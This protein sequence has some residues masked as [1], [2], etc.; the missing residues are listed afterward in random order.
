MS[1]VQNRG[2]ICDFELA[3]ATLCG[4]LR[5]E[6]QTLKENCDFA[7]LICSNWFF[8]PE[9]LTAADWDTTGALQLARKP[10]LANLEQSNA[11]IAE[12][13]QAP[14][15]LIF[16]LNNDGPTKDS[17]N[18]SNRRNMRD[19]QEVAEICLPHGQELQQVQDKSVLN[20]IAGLKDWPLGA[21]K[22]CMAV[23]GNCRK[24]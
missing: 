6:C 19:V 15:V 1:S 24:Q 9:N 11:S 18:E 21:F 13:L 8:F 2:N 7:V 4:D 10:S 14:W 17:Q 20:G 5:V 16:H 22:G 12:R 23:H 3:G